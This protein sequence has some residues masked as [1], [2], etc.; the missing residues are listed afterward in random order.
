MDKLKMYNDI[1]LQKVQE[2]S[3]KYI[4]TYDVKNV[5][6]QRLLTITLNSIMPQPHN[7]NTDLAHVRLVDFYLCLRE[8]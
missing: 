1:A 8:N 3:I 7:K 4:C 5:C 2:D 6:T